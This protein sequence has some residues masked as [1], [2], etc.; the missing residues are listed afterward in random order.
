[1]NKINPTLHSLTL[2]HPPKPRRRY[3]HVNFNPHPKSRSAIDMPLTL[4]VPSPTQLVIPSELPDKSALEQAQH[5]E[6][7]MVVLEPA[8]VD[9]LLL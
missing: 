1:M 8:V 3:T 5:D 6:G 9:S 4:I 7:D 2:T